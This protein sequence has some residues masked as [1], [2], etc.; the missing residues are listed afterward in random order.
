MFEPPF[1]RFKTLYPGMPLELKSE[2]DA[3]MISWLQVPGRLTRSVAETRTM[4]PWLVVVAL[5]LILLF[6]I[7]LMLCVF[8]KR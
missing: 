7:G 4:R 2:L 1:Y 8:L 6:Q 5:G 3:P